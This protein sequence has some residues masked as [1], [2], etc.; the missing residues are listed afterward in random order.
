MEGKRKKKQYRVIC[1][2]CKKDSVLYCRSLCRRCYDDQ[3]IREEFQVSS[4]KGSKAR[5]LGAFKNGETYTS[6]PNLREP[7]PTDAMPGSEEKIRIMEYR[8]ANGFSIFSPND[9]NGK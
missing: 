7:E 2:Y 4:K 8:A 5:M 1:G 6:S 9:R 3:K